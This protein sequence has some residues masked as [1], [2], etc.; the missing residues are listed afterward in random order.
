MRKASRKAGYQAIRCAYQGIVKVYP[1]GFGTFLA[2][3]TPISISVRN[4]P[5]PGH[6]VLVYVGYD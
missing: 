6:G 5:G 2:M 4:Q 1:D 3:Y